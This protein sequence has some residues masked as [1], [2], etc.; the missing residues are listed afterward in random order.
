M[1]DA[2]SNGSLN[3]CSAFTFESYLYQLKK[4][5]RSGNH[6]LIQVAKRLQE[7]SQIPIQ[8]GEQ[9]RPIE[10][11]HPNNVYIISPTSCCQVLER[12]NSGQFLC[13]VFSELKSY[14]TQP[15]DS[16]I[17]GAYLCGSSKMEVLNKSSLNGRAMILVDEHGHRLALSALH[18]LE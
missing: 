11:K 13:R 10:M 3:K 17:Y 7:R 5:I 2:T 4:M 12:T 9:S 16:R 14:H 15:C 1:A 8:P 18:D 6:V